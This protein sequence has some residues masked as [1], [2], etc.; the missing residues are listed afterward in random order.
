MNMKTAYRRNMGDFTALHGTK[1][2]D[3]AQ[4]FE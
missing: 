1:A 3:V 4:K 2:I